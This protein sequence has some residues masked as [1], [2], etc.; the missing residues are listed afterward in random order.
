MLL[1]YT[2]FLTTDVLKDFFLCREGGT[3]GRQVHL[4]ASAAMF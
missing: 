1:Y 3:K 2:T 4:T